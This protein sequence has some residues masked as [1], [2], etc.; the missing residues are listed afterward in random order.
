[1]NT[2]DIPGRGVAGG[3]QGLSVNDTDDLFDPGRNAAVKILRLE[4]REDG[5]ADD[6]LACEVGERSFQ[7]VSHLDSDGAVVFRYDQNGA[8]IYLLT[9]ELPFLRNPQGKLL[10]GLRRCRS[11]HQHCDLA[12]FPGFERRQ[13]LLQRGFLLGSEGAGQVD[14]MPSQR[15]NRHLRHDEDGPA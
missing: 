4:A 11:D 2:A 15:G 8:V 13:R 6:A 7:T 14:Y 9:S 10:D 12:A 5:F 3:W 1:M